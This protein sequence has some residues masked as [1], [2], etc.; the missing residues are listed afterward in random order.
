[1]IHVSICF[2]FFFFAFALLN[3][4]LH[5]LLWPCRGLC[6]LLQLLQETVAVAVAAAAVGHVVAAVVVCGISSGAAKRSSSL[7]SNLPQAL[8]IFSTAAI[9]SIYISILLFFFV[10]AGLFGPASLLYFM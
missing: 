9:I 4:N 3:V 8:N 6:L 5:R 10:L 1:M 7:I 2:C